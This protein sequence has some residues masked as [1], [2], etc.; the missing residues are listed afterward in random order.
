MAVQSAVAPREHSSR[1][2]QASLIPRCNSHVSTD[3]KLQIFFI[4]RPLDGFG[5][6]EIIDPPGRQF[7]GS[8]R[9]G[10]K[11]RIATCEPQRA[12]LA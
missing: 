9:T 4:D 1:R 6:A 7:D 8:E 5:A 3:L 11:R 2:A 10:A 12:Q